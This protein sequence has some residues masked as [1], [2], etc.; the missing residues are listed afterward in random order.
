MKIISNKRRMKI[1]KYLLHKVYKI[2]VPDYKKCKIYEGILPIHVVSSDRGEFKLF[3]P[4]RMVFYRARSFFTKEP[5]TVEWINTFTA[6]ETL[7]DLGANVGVYSLL[8]AK[9]G[10]K[11]VAFEPEPQNFSVL[12]MNIYLNELSD[13]I[14]PLNIAISDRT[15]IDFLYMPVFGIGHAFNQFGVLPELSAEPA[16]AAARQF[17]KASPSNAAKQFVIAYT[18]DEFLAAF[19]QFFP[20]HIKIDVDGLEN[21]VISGASKTLEN[22]ALKSL[23]VEFNSRAE[24]SIQAIEFIQSKGFRI[25]SMNQRI[26]KNFFNYIF[27]R[28]SPGLGK[29]A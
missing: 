13:L 24:A 15:T 20:T 23:L 9:A 25:H 4:S 11:V 8:A 21:L 2:N 16:S 5:E 6:Q 1:L 26:E 7:F 14:V 28:P 10:V 3:C 29:I 27:R 12:T 17:V 18:L 19:P 22:P